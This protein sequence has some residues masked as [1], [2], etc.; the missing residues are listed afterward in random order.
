MKKIAVAVL[1]ILSASI[2]FAQSDA[3]A[4]QLLDEV[5]KKMNTYSNIYAAFTYKLNNTEAN[6]QQ[7]TK[8]DVT[9][10]G[11]MYNVNFMGTKQLFDGKKVYTILTEDEEVNISNAN[12][13]DEETL[14]PSRFFSFYKKGFTYKWDILQNVSGRK[15]QYVKL[16]PI[17]SNS[18]I[19]NILLGID[20]G[21]NHIYKLIETGNNHTVTT[22]T[23][24]DFKTDQTLPA[25]LFTFDENKY[26]NLGYLINK[27]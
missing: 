9:M 16:T 27:L 7:E 22:L 20:I 8:G 17:D 15:I 24:T 4:K 1:L 2:T 23:I 25:A 21:T 6:V 18:D 3:K 12:A 13:D 19:N 10:K 5:S 11:D 26:K 14:T